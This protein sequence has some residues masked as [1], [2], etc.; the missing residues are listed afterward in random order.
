MQLRDDQ[1][2]YLGK[3]KNN[4]FSAEDIHNFSPDL[5]DK[6]YALPAGLIDSH[7]KAAFYLALAEMVDGQPGVEA[8]IPIWLRGAAEVNQGIGS[9]SDFI[10]SYNADQALARNGV[11][12]NGNTRRVPITCA[13]ERFFD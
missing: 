12:I 5:V 2:S 4:S 6:Y 7:P 1:L 3:V 9:Q 8:T 13:R 11:A 10:R